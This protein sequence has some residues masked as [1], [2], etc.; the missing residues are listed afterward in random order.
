[1]LSMQTVRHCQSM[2]VKE[3]TKVRFFFVRRPHTLHRR[4]G[5]YRLGEKTGIGAWHGSRPKNDQFLNSA[6]WAVQFQ[7]RWGRRLSFRQINRQIY[8]AMAE[9]LGPVIFDSWVSELLDTL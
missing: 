8:A 1:M 9:R 7:V 2:H 6:K 4:F 3:C 5:F